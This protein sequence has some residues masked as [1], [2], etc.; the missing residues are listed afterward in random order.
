MVCTSAFAAVVQS[1]LF[2]NMY[3]ATSRGYPDIAAQAVNFEYIFYGKTR[4]FLGTS[5]SAPVRLFPS[6]VP[7]ASSI[8]GHPADP[9]C[10]DRGGRDL[11]V[12]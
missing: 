11:V 5:C 6:S 4:A 3:S 1:D 7:S 12:E 9:L 10:T 8:L 2:L